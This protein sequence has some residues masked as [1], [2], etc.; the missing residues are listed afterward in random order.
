MF[1]V[2]SL[3]ALL[4]SSVTGSPV[5]VRNSLI[6]LPMRRTFSNV[7]DILGH[8]EAR[9]AAFREYS[10]HGPRA[11][12]P[13]LNM[14][15]GY[16]VA[17]NVGDPPITYNLIVD[18]SSSITWVGADNA[19]VSPTGVN[20]GEV[21]AVDYKFGSFQGTIFRDHLTLTNELS[22]TEMPIAVAS[23]P[24]GFDGV[25]GIGP[26]VSSL[27]ALQNLNSRR[28]TIP[29]VTEY[30]FR[31]HAI[32]QSVVGIFFQPV[33]QG[34]VNHGQLTFG[35][36]DHTK[37]TG[38]IQYTP[39]TSVPPSSRYWGIKQ[40]ITYGD[41]ELIRRT[42]GIVD[43]GCTF[44]YIASDAYEK[45]K[46]ATGGI[47]N[48]N[49]LLQITTE[50]Y[51][52][53]RVLKFWIGRE[54]YNLEPHAQIWPRFLNY[55]FGGNVDDIFLVVKSLDTSIG[56]GHSFINGYVFLQRFYT[57]FDSDNGRVGFA[58]TP[59]TSDTTN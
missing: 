16:T 26:E 44:L 47:V 52:V 35:G 1:S 46:D 12:V 33:D 10:T 34:V 56:V 40:R 19:Y 50:K 25:L 43:C 31:Q 49:G 4:A 23:T 45:Y 58:Q 57:V 30:L 48:A 39:V 6:T 14:L 9:M 27:G 55:I 42:S 54:I 29:P 28:Y 36:V 20:T 18:S 2:V 51:E 13:L 5:E 37:Y 21:V 7:T 11:D 3:L 38:T 59:F 17:V 41:T 53:L 32:Y 24:L 15:M 22:I 8:D